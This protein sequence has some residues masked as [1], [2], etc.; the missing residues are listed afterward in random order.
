[1]DLPSAVKQWQTLLGEP[2]VLLGEAASA[3]YG[4][5]TSGT[6]AHIPAAL[7]VKDSASLREIMRIATRHQVP[8]YPIRDRK[9]VV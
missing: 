4:A 2:N 3:A 9:S 7:R 8:V 6:H 1:M 5:D